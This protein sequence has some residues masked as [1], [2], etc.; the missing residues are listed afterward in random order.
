MGNWIWKIHEFSWNFL[1]QKIWGCRGVRYFH[2]RFESE[3]SA[4][5]SNMWGQN[6]LFFEIHTLKIFYFFFFFFVK[7]SV[8]KLFHTNEKTI[9]NESQKVLFWHPQVWVIS[10]KFLIKNHFFEHHTN[11]K[12]IEIESQFSLGGTFSNLLDVKKSQNKFIS[13]TIVNTK[14]IVHTTVNTYCFLMILPLI[15][16]YLRIVPFSVHFTI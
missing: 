7:N 9:K 15:M 1:V 5:F 6:Y 4:S 2:F 3:K 8:F 16:L 14:P 11:G 10:M 13:F 12:T